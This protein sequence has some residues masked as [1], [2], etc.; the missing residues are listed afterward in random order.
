MQAP[1]NSQVATELLSSQAWTREKSSETTSRKGKNIRSSS[2][3]ISGQQQVEVLFR[4]YYGRVKGFFRRRGCDE[5]EAKELVQ[6]VF[7]RASRGHSRLRD[8]TA[9]AGWMFTIAGNV[10]RSHIRDRRA[11]KRDATEVALQGMDDQGEGLIAEQ[12]LTTLDEGPLHALLGKERQLELHR[13]I[14]EL[15]P[16]MRA[17]LELRVGQDRKYR[18]IAQILGVSESTVK[19]Q[20]FHAKFKLKKYLV[21]VFGG[22]QA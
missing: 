4:Q 18:E 7:L 1:L 16:Q 19:T 6:T 21:Q 22:N 13:A 3:V 8:P 10:W 12:G 20:I 2:Q 14:S 9:E 5:E 17:C 11:E 15:P